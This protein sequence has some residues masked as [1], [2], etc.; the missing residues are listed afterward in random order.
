MKVTHVGG[1]Y[2][3]RLFYYYLV[4]E[5][6]VSIESKLLTSL[7]LIDKLQLQLNY[8]EMQELK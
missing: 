1:T 3:V 4:P 5:P 2:K 6:T 8:L 7:L